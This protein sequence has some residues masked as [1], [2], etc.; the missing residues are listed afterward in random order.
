M[1]DPAYDAIVIGGGPNGLTAAITLAARGRSVLLLEAQPSLGGALATAALTLPGFHHDVFSA[2]HPA[3]AASPAFARLPLARYGLRWVHPPIAMAHPFMDGRAAAL[4]RDLNR[5]VDSLDRLH[6]GDG[7]RW[8]A[9][10]EPYLRHG[11]ALRGVM[12]SAFPPVA[13]GAR[14]L[15]ALGMDGT[16]EFARLLLTAATTL[17]AETF[18]GTAAPAWFF[19]AAM[20]G[21]VP[22]QEAGSAIAGFYLLLLGHLVGWPSPAG[23]AERLAEALA[24]HFHALGGASRTCAPVVRVIAGGGRVRA[25]LTADGACYPTRTVIA[26]VTPHALLR[27]AGEQF[28]SGYVAKMARYRSGPPTFKVDWALDGPVPWTAAAARQAGTVHVGGE[29]DDLFAS[30]AQGRAGALPARPFLLF[31][32]QSLADPARA[33]AGKQTAWA[34]THTPRGVDWA[35][36]ALP[37][38]ERIEAQVERFAPGFRDRIIARHLLTPPMLAA[39]NANLVEGDVGNGSTAL[40]QLVFRPIPTL[41]PYRTPLRGLYLASAATFPGGAV[42]GVSGEAAARLALRG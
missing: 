19:G 32:Q 35:A 34:Y 1:S 8:R 30:L 21:D 37:F 4:H 40:D 24:A 18:R 7:R 29:T 31:G 22:P 17:A 10:I 20:H 12:L 11:D 41:S 15:T 39:R 42:H 38:A 27:L 5:T 9:L 36:H 28:S 16:L 14:L 2:V 23:G 25:V 13:S 6:P 33:P 26:N 3:A